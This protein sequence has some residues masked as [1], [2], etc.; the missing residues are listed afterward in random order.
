MDLIRPTRL[1]GDE[2]RSGAAPSRPHRLATTDHRMRTAALLTCIL[3]CTPAEAQPCSDPTLATRPAR[4][5]SIQAHTDGIAKEVSKVEVVPSAR[6]EYID[7]EMQVGHEKRDA[8]S[9]RF[10]RVTE[11]PDYHALEIMK[12]FSKIRI[13]L[14][15]AEIS[16]T[17]RDQASNLLDA[18]QVYPEL[19]SSFVEYCRLDVTRSDRAMTSSDQNTAMLNIFGGQLFLYNVLRCAIEEMREP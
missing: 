14:N 13:S 11:R 5:K 16:E 3:A 12:K 2:S 18:M 4:S 17:V 1:Y 19:L 8:S 9:D 7:K 15:K 10:N 6:A